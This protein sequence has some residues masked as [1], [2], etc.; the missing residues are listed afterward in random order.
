MQSTHWRAH[1]G[2]RD[3]QGL[4]IEPTIRL[5]GVLIENLIGCVLIPV[6]GLR[7]IGVRDALGIHPIFGLL[8]LRIINLGGWVDWGSETLKEVTSIDAFTVDQD[9]ISIIRAGR[10]LIW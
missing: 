3:S 9:V 7:G 10:M 4:I 2:V 6:I 8:I 1:T 5:L